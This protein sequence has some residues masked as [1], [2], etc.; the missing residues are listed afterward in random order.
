MRMN[1]LLVLLLSTSVMHCSYIPHDVL[2]LGDDDDYDGG[3]VPPACDS[4]CDETPGDA[5][6]DLLDQ[7]ADMEEVL[8]ET[9]CDDAGSIIL[10]Q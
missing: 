1:L 10:L 7:L 4:C 3:E 2:M 6:S 9:G 5:C 8:K